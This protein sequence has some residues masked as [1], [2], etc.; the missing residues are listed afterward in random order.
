VV[1]EDDVEIEDTKAELDED[2][3]GILAFTV[4]DTGALLNDNRDDDDDDE[5]LPSITIEVKDATDTCALLGANVIG[6]PPTEGEDDDDDDEGD[7]GDDDE[8]D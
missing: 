6:A 7:D 3:L 8:D 4:T 5:K 1:F 2:R